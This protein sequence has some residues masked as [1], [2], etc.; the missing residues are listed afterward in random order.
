VLQMQTLIDLQVLMLLFLL[1][2]LQ[3]HQ[4]GMQQ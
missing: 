1:G 4:V 3:L 2:M